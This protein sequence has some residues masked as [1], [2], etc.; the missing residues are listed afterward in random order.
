MD[1]RHDSCVKSV[2][3]ADRY[4]GLDIEI[5]EGDLQEDCSAEIKKLKGCA[6]PASA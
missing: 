4:W 2:R 1:S 6:P 5:T 3:G